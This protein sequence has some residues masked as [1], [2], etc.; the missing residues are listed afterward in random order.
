M[1]RAVPFAASLAILVAALAVP[2]FSGNY[3]VDVGLTII[4]YAILGLGLNIVVGYAGLL[5][6]GYAAFFAIGA[7][8]TALLETLA[9]FNFWATLPFSLAFAGISGVVVGYP[10]LR[11]RSDYLAIVTLGFGEI[12][13]ITATNLDITGGP[14]GI[15]GINPA[16]LF[17][18]EISSPRAI[19]ELGMGFLILVLAFAIRLGSSR[20]GRAWTSIRE[21]EA[22]AE[23]VG[24]PTL[25]VK[26]LA[27]VMGAL[28]GGMAG[29]LFAA[30][31]GTID[32]TAFTYLQSVTILIIVVLGGRG[33]IPG[34]LLGAAIVAGTP[35]AL[36]F[37][38]LWRIFAFAVA[39]ILLMLVRPQGLWPAR[40][41]RPPVPPREAADQATLN[42]PEKGSTGEALLEVRD[43]RKTYGGVT[44]V[45]AVSFRVV[46]GEILSIIGPNG[47]GKTTV[48]NCLT[49]VTRPT[50]GSVV[51]RGNSI[52]GRTP[53]AVVHLGIARTFQ[54]IRLFPDLTAF[55]NVLV[56]M[57]HHARASVAAQVL[58]LP[59]A[60]HEEADHHAEA[61]RWL[62]F[63]GLD[64][65]A[66]VRAADL[67]Y[68]DQRRLEI[69]RALA[70]RP[71]LLLL[72]E[73]AAGM[74][75][76]EKTALMALIRGI[77]DVGITVLLIE[78]DMMLVMGISDRIVVM[79][80]G[81]VIAEGSPAEIQTNQSVIDAYLGSD[82]EEGADESSLAEADAWG[83]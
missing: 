2:A 24:V 27:Y 37:L 68:G 10:T 48:F 11:L 75:P 83:S 72:D 64:A 47:A 66:G 8:T 1:T 17:G 55:E 3:I 58:S 49:G 46:R 78:H 41:R 18:F 73:P 79:D 40:L 15:Y 54:G 65:R 20:L 60:R 23:A 16:S 82:E 59:S 52:V 21:D 6:L 22:A 35:E 53:H 14:N 50:S 9:G 7:Y 77:R 13:R 4:T 39:L 70:S 12:V 34:V 67:P 74:N 29:S 43:L 57:D 61:R 26:L 51:W 44:A 42:V 31:F 71:S 80:H 19:Y 28:I 38:N 62:G 76:T 45:S 81:T 32:P 63:V 69:G 33:S 25:A 5:D 56:G 36:R 30:R